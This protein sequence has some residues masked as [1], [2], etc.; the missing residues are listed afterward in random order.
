M[1]SLNQASPAS[2]GSMDLKNKQGKKKTFGDH[3][4]RLFSCGSRRQDEE[5]GGMNSESTVTSAVSDTCSSPSIAQ[6][7]RSEMNRRSKQISFMSNYTLIEGLENRTISPKIRPVKN[8]P[9]LI[10]FLNK[11]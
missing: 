5:C 8:T 11:Y 9:Y 4:R 6:S 2:L 10:S 3:V 1:Q 7:M